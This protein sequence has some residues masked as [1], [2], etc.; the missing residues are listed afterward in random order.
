[1]VRELRA[2]GALFL[3]RVIFFRSTIAGLRSVRT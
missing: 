1:M 3:E 2:H